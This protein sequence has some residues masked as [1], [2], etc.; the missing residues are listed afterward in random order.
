VP[1]SFTFYLAEQQIIIL[2]TLYAKAKKAD[3]SKAEENELPLLNPTSMILSVAMLL[4]WLGEHRNAASFS[5]AGHAI[6]KAI[7]GVLAS[8]ANRTADLGGKLG[9]KA[10]GGVV[11]EAV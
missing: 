5:H 3:L 9:C 4:S 8:P 11:A 7:D 2:V 6:E 1:A 10:F